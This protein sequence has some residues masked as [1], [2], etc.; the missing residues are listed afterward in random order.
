V[1]VPVAV[2]VEV[3][4]AVADIEDVALWLDVAVGLIVLVCVRVLEADMLLV[5]L[6]DAV[7]VPLALIELVAEGV[8]V[9][10]TDDVPV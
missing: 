10:V 6:L 3:G 7:D 4:D 9:A 2:S 5:A 8:A 1:P